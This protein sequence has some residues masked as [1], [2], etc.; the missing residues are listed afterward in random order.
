MPQSN[1]QFEEM[2]A[3]SQRRLDGRSPEDLARTAGVRPVEGG[4][5][6]S[7]LGQA[8]TVRLPE[9]LTEPPLSKWHTLTLLHYLDL[10]DGT[11]P[12]GERMAFAS[13]PD[14]L[15]RGGGFDTDAEKQIASLLGALSLEELRRRCRALGA[16]F[17]PS[18]ADF[19]AEF[20]F[21][22]QYPLW[23]NLWFADEEFP[24]SG[25]LLVDRSAP[26]YLSVEDAVT[27]GSLL[28][29]LLTG[30]GRWQV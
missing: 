5:C 22:P 28:L 9:C 4:V 30:A 24:A 13:Y 26:H 14:G 6:F 19:C 7:S 1:R 27:V 8:V 29:D 23:L 11:P 16:A 18:N 12:T 2:L 25:R 3:V 15:V 21:A 20:S 10:A 17:P